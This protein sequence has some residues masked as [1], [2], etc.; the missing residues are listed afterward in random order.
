MKIDVI[1]EVNRKG[2]G[3][4]ERTDIVQD[5]RRGWMVWIKFVENGK[6]ERIKD[7]IRLMIF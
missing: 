1:L 7:E 3:G 6:G 5:L 4:S 2:S